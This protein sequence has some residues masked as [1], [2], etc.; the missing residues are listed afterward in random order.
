MVLPKVVVSDF[1]V[2]GAIVLSFCVHMAFSLRDHVLGPCF[3]LKKAKL[4]GKIR[5]RSLVPICSHSVVDGLP[6]GAK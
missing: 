1:E 2:P 3:Y 5:H 4:W 6:I